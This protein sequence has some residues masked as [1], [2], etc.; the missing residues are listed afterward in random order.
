MKILLLS[1]IPPC[2]NLTAG[3]VLSALVRFVPKDS[4]CFYIVSN[5][6]VEIELSPEFANIP[7]RMETKPN[8]NWN[9]LPQRRS[10]KKFSSLA[11][12]FAEKVG[13]SFIVKK[14][15]ADSVEFGKSQGVDRVWAVLQ[16]QTTIRMAESVAKGIG[17]PLHSHVWD[18]FSWWADAHALDGFTRRSTQAKFDSAI[19]SSKFVAAASEPM[20]ELYSSTFNVNSVPL[21]ASHSL[22]LAKSPQVD[23]PDDN[24]I[25]IGMA[26]QFYASTEWECL[27]KMLKCSRWRIGKRKVKVVVMGPQ[28]PP[29]CYNDSNVKFLGWKNQEDAASIL[30][31]CDAL[32]CPYPF[33]DK[34][35][36]VS[37]YS[38]PSKFVLYLAAGKPIIFH[39]PVYA[40]PTKYITKRSC[41][42]A[43][44]SLLPTALYN[45]FEKLVNEEQR[46]KE[47]AENAQEAFKKDFTL[48]SLRESFSQF[49]GSDDL[50]T[51][52][53]N[54]QHFLDPTT[55]EF[56]SL[57]HEVKNRKNRSLVGVVQSL[58]FNI[59]IYAKR[60]KKWLRWNVISKIPPF[61][62]FYVEIDYYAKEVE[63]LN[64]LISNKDCLKR[65]T[66]TKPKID[67]SVLISKDPLYLEDYSLSNQIDN[68]ELTVILRESDDI[69]ILV[70]QCLLSDKHISKIYF[71]VCVSSDVIHIKNELS[72]IISDICFIFDSEEHALSVL[73][74]KAILG[75]DYLIKSIKSNLVRY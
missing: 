18:P 50:L 56:Y 17:V 57:E 10:L 54:K 40:S 61:K 49:I 63:R 38:F 41:G 52:S 35:K 15:I 45:A 3:L 13:E 4:I 44:C 62:R 5:P 6:S 65:E 23:I 73:D 47:I 72:K 42:I 24:C 43:V 33:D 8:E 66:E 27:L 69:G 36:E 74:T 58:S 30:S 55:D 46:Y 70:R 68:N 14:R 37:S 64:T 67:H 48:L 11:T 20:A 22:E 34:M 39:G 21:I 31:L 7:M 25:L 12:F 2:E 32:Y 16:G 53:Q 28:R 51:T 75:K 1:D 29:G 9:F 26:G 59:R 19:K 60:L 71:D